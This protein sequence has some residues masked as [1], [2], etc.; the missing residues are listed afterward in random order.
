MGQSDTIR[1]IHHGR[2]KL[3]MKKILLALLFFGYTALAHAEHKLQ[4]STPG[5]RTSSAR[6]YRELPDDKGVMQRVLVVDM[7]V[8]G[9]AQVE[10]DIDSPL[11]FQWYQNDKN[12]VVQYSYPYYQV[13]FLSV[14]S[15]VSPADKAKL[16]NGVFYMTLSDLNGVRIV[17]ALYNADL[18][19]GANKP[20]AKLPWDSYNPKGT[21]GWA[22]EETLE[23]APIKHLLDSPPSDLLEF[24]PKFN[25]IS[26][27]QKIHFW[28]VS[29]THLTL[30]TILR[31]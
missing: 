31:V 29:Y 26:R 18:P 6:A 15:S 21:W 5:T 27:P 23:T 25:A 2:M 22:I 1:A 10:I 4:T 11:M 7:K 17:N 16:L 14:P 3:P 19:K 13:K 8:P 24:C 28:P 12:K 20:I 9:P 30:P